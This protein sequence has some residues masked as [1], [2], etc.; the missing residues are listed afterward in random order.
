[1]ILKIDALQPGMIPPQFF[2][3][4]KC[5]EQPLFGDPIDPANQRLVILFQSLQREAP[6][7][8]QP[9]GFGSP[10]SKMFLGKLVKLPLNI[11][12]ADG[13]SIFEIDNSAASR[14]RPWTAGAAW[15][16]LPRAYKMSK[17]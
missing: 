2:R 13:F 9:V 8:Q 1:M 3:L 10:E 14:G 12:G 15:R 7:L 16:R 17:P 4:H 5:F 11:E 6:V